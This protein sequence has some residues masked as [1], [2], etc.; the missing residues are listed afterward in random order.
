MGFYLGL[1]DSNYSSFC[2]CAKMIDRRLQEIGARYFMEPG[3]ADD[4]T[5]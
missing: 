3:F 5:G 4:A 1:G 2:N